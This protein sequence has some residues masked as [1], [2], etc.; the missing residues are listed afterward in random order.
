MSGRA[1]V[2]VEWRQSIDACYS[3]KSNDQLVE[4]Y[5]R[6]VEVVVIYSKFSLQLEKTNK[7][8]LPYMV[9]LLLAAT[10]QA[11]VMNATS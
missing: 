7:N 1:A 8:K 11:H 10:L 4:F 6:R 5:C 9:I 3:L 2:R